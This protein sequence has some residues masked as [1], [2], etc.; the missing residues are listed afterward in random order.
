[1]KRN[2][3]IMS[4]L[5]QKP[6]KKFEKKEKNIL[7][8][9]LICFFIMIGGL[10]AGIITQNTIFYL[11]AGIGIFPLALGKL[12][13]S[14]SSKG[15]YKWNE[16]SSFYF[17]LSEGKEKGTLSNPVVIDYSVELP[18]KV[19]I[20]KSDIFITFQDCDISNLWLKSCQNIL[21]KNC[22]I[23]R[24]LSDFCQK[25]T[26]ENCRI[27][28]SISQKCSNVNFTNS[29]FEKLL[30]LY[31]SQDCRIV[32]CSIKTLKL[33]QAKD[34]IIRFCTISKI[35]SKLSKL[36]TF[37]GNTIPERQGTNFNTTQLRDFIDKWNLKT[38]IIMAIIILG[39]CFFIAN[40]LN[41]GFIFPI[42]LILYIG[43]E[44]L[45]IALQNFAE[46]HK[47]KRE[48]LQT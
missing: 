35:K 25:I 12:F 34:N 28:T 15:E 26:L 22:Y 40:L 38:R 5:K 7:V 14:G 11:I 31:S 2:N 46:K 17:Q 13:Y 19:L 24:F 48:K 47:H 41:V 16:L 29:T 37:E 21:L 43:M 18:D 32:E 30:N 33:Y 44:I 39:S 27:N 8:V 23:T 36:N 4:T 9:I 3:S 10:I 45:F 42:L 1:M 20:E 6:K